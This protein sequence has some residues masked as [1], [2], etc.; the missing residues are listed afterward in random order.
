MSTHINTHYTHLEEI[1]TGY[2]NTFSSCESFLMHHNKVWSIFSSSLKW[3]HCVP[4]HI[5]IMPLKKGLAFNE[6]VGCS[7]QIINIWHIWHTYAF[8]VNGDGSDKLQPFTIGVAHKPVCFKGKTSK[9]LC[10]DYQ[11][12]PKVW[13]QTV[14]FIKWIGLWDQALNVEG[15]YILLLVK[16]F[17]GHPPAERRY[18]RKFQM[19]VSMRNYQPCNWLTWVSHCDW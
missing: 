8:V 16:N 7:S 2:K 5:G 3:T 4:L 17:P 1:L 10:F 13:M 11:N 6:K 15:W 9:Q 19:L 12:N 18:H 14:L